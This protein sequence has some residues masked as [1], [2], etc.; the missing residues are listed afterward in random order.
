MT[1]EEYIIKIKQLEG[2]N[3]QQA[4]SICEEALTKFPQ[5]A[6]LYYSKACLIWL[7][8]PNNYEL[9]SSLLKRATDLNSTWVES[10]LKIH[11]YQVGGKELIW[12]ECLNLNLPVICNN[13]YIKDFWNMKDELGE[14][15][16]CVDVRTHSY[17]DTFSFWTFN[18]FKVDMQIRG[19]IIKWVDTLFTK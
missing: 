11:K 19:N 15:E 10:T 18:C 4:L 17:N 12:L 9:F 16:Y 2:I 6:K 3:T 14:N 1:V 8:E 13:L 5:D 7:Q